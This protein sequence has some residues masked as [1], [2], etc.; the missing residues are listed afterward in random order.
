[1]I[2]KK[3]LV[4]W[5]N[6]DYEWFFCSPREKT[7]E[8]RCY[9]QDFLTLQDETSYHER[10][11]MNQSVLPDIKLIWS[12]VST[13]SSSLTVGWMN[14][15][16][17]DSNHYLRQC[18]TNEVIRWR[19]HLVDRYKCKKRR[20]TGCQSSFSHAVDDVKGTASV[21]AELCGVALKHLMI[22]IFISS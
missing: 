22:I 7:Q 17:A 10:N 9:E 6:Y 8:S 1:M 14:A 12:S 21:T 13:W 16:T 18:R 19:V 20:F 2:F 4:N 15:S 11:I 3:L 5:G